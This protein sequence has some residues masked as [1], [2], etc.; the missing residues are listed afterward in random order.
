MGASGGY[1]YCTDRFP[2]VLIVRLSS[3]VTGR[4]DD[5]PMESSRLVRD[6]SSEKGVTAFGPS[7]EPVK[8]EL[9]RTRRYDYMV[10]VGPR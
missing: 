8:H 4:T 1:G 5:L 7:G 10:V 3:S 6:G 9:H 2:A